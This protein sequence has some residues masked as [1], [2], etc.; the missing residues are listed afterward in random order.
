MREVDI[1][2]KILVI[3]C[4][5]CGLQYDIN[6]IVKAFYPEYTVK[7]LEPG[8]RPH[9]ENIYKLP[10]FMEVRLGGEVDIKY[11]PEKDRLSLSSENKNTNQTLKFDI[12]PEKGAKNSFKLFLYDTLCKL[13]GRKL[14]WGALTGVRP[15]KIA[16]TMLEEGAA[17]DE[18]GIR[19]YNNFRVSPEKT[20]LSLKIAKRERELL[21]R[22]DYKKGYSLYVGIPFCPTTCLYC[23]FTSYPMAT[24]QT[25]ADEYLEALGRELDCR[26]YRRRIP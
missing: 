22:L 11:I 23:S 24:W 16:M 25:R 10:V 4:D 12:D 15:T 9:D 19:M 20:A 3:R 6:A 14:P 5:T 18:I 13:T 2:E 17:D 26:P 1:K 8:Q 7:V 21:E